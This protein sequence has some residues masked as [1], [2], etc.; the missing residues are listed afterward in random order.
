MK[1]KLIRDRIP[2][3]MYSS[4]SVPKTRILDTQEFILKLKE[5]LLEEA[6]EVLQTTTKEQLTEELADLLEVL[7][8]LSQTM[9]IS[10][11]DLQT[12]QQQKRQKRGGFSKQLCLEL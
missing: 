6:N 10:E 8:T 4:G 1:E 11:I 12:T 7:H 3:I 5:K 2:E 9:N